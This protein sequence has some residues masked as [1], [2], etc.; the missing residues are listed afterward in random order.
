MVTFYNLWTFYTF[1][2]T[3]MLFCCAI[4]VVDVFDVCVAWTA[5]YSL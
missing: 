1:G 5:G 3:A 2:T 4:F